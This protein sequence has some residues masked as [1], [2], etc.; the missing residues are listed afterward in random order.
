MILIWHGCNPSYSHVDVTWQVNHD[1]H[2][3]CGA[4]PLGQM[5]YLD[6]QQTLY[7]S[8]EPNLHGPEFVFRHSIVTQNCSLTF[9]NSVDFLRYL[10]VN[11]FFLMWVNKTAKTGQLRL[12]QSTLSLKNDD[13]FH[14]QFVPIK[15]IS[16]NE[17]YLQITHTQS[18]LF[19]A[20]RP[21]SKLAIQVFKCY[22]N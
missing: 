21:L 10:V 3:N 20:H 19:R 12:I 2:V 13:F 11:F 8:S 14:R 16:D 6:L 7:G 17:M 1:W 5:L 18:E 22:R 9:P 4:L 15:R